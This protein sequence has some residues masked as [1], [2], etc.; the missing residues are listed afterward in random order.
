MRIH[1]FW[2]VLAAALFCGCASKP[3]KRG[4]GDVGQ[5]ILQHAVARGGSPTT[6]SL[7]AIGGRWRYSQDDDGV[8]IRMPREHYPKVENFL[9]QAFGTPMIE[10]K[11]IPGGGRLGVYRLSTNGGG[12]QFGYDINGT[13]VVVLRPMSTLEILRGVKGEIKEMEKPE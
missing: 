13:Q 11:K 6:N 4:R 3:F 2:V 8:V 7:P 1:A 5:F 10:P 9:R 12:I